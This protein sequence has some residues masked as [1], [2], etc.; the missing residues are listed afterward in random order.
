MSKNTSEWEELVAKIRAWDR[1]EHDWAASS[2]SIDHVSVSAK[3]SFIKSLMLDYELK[4]KTND[5]NT[6][7]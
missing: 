3:D 2:K 4:K 6:G 7:A 1:S 5:K